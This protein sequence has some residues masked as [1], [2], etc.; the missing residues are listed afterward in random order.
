MFKYEAKSVPGIVIRDF[1]FAFPHDTDPNWIPGQ[2]VRGQFFNGISLTRLTYGCAELGALEERM[3]KAWERLLERDLAA[4][5]AYSAGLECINGYAN[6][7]FG[8]NTPSVDTSLRSMPV[9]FKSS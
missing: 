4:R 6:M 2:R 8:K 7:P 5:L 9:P 3:A 1:D